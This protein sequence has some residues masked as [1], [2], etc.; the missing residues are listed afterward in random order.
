MSALPASSPS[1]VH[2]DD[3]RP[4]IFGLGIVVPAIAMLVLASVFVRSWSLLLPILI[5]VFVVLG[6]VAIVLFRRGPTVTR[7]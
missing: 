4:T 6:V 1:R 7:R 5:A 2:V 3:A